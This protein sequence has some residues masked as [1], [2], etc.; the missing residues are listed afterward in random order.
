[1]ARRL[2]RSILK[3]LADENITNDARDADEL[4]DFAGMILDEEEP[5]SARFLNTDAELISVRS[6]LDYAIRGLI[7]RGKARKVSPT[8]IQESISVLLDNYE[9]YLTFRVLRLPR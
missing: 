2:F 5:S 9:R 7:I 8:Q 3:D 4:V 1:L 6:S